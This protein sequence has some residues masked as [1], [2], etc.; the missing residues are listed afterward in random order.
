MKRLIPAAATLLLVSLPAMAL[1]VNGDVGVYYDAKSSSDLL[2]ALTGDGDGFGLTTAWNFGGP[3]AHFEYR[4]VEIDLDQAAGASSETNTWRLGG[5]Y[6]FALNPQ[7]NV[8]GNLEYLDMEDD[9]VDGG[10]VINSTGFGLHAEGDYTPIKQL[11]VGLSLGYLKLS[12]DSPQAPGTNLDSDGIEYMIGAT[13]NIVDA[14]AAS[15][16]YRSY[17]GKFSDC[18]SCGGDNETYEHTGLMLEG[19]YRFKL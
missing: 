6:E 11:T 19:A 9:Y 15:L 3:T 5:G 1:Q 16:N 10:L 14:F 8:G 4:T 2:T 12:G 13:Y 18:G 7:F 17:M